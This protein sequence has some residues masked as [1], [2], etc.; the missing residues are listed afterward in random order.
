MCILYIVKFTGYF[1]I[2]FALRIRDFSE[3]VQTRQLTIL[4]RQL[5]FPAQHLRLK[6][7]YQKTLNNFLFIFFEFNISQKFI[8]GN[9]DIFKKVSNSRTR[10]PRELKFIV[11]IH[12]HNIK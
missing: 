9:N 8:V 12:K 1:R 10:D 5:D 6:S 3:A 2:D 11:I 7:K 4:G